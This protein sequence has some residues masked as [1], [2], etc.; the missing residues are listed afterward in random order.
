MQLLIVRAESSEIGDVLFTFETAEEEEEEGAR[1]IKHGFIGIQRPGEVA[2]IMRAAFPRL[3]L[4]CEAGSRNDWS[5][6]SDL[7]GLLHCDP[8]ENK[9]TPILGSK[10]FEKSMHYDF[11]QA[12]VD[13]HRA[14]YF[15]RR[16][17]SRQVRGDLPLTL[18][19]AARSYH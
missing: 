13:I 17:A 4:P 14:G 11:N 19:Q 6:S 2:A 7:G 15:R 10:L 8:G 3:L 18:R 5:V 16:E 12:F 9:I 1:E